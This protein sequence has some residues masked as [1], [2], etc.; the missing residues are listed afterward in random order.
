MSKKP[1]SFLKIMVPAGGATPAPP[2]GPALGQRKVNIMEFCKAFNAI[3][4]GPHVAKGTPVPVTVMIYKDKSFDITAKKPATSYLIKQ[5]LSVKKGS[6]QAG[7]SSCG[8]LS[9]DDLKKIAELKAVDLNVYD[10]EAAMRIVSGCA[11]SIGVE[12]EGAKT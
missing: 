6:S 11:K 7:R 4:H 9:Q 2:L 8:V 12:V 5:A 3:D 10:L 1:E